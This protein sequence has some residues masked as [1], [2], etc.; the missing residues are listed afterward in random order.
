[1]GTDTS[2]I[3]RTNMSVRS[4]TTVCEAL[5]YILYLRKGHYFAL[6]CTSRKAIKNFEVDV[7]V[8]KGALRFREKKPT[9][10]VGFI[11]SMFPSIV[12]IW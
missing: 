9:L 6:V 2:Y 4:C 11:R 5:A 10:D 3:V 1:M 12:V 7:N 8:Q